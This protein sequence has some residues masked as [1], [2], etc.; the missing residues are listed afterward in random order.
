MEYIK[1]LLGTGLTIT[2]AWMLFANSLLKP[3]VLRWRGVLNS[4]PFIRRGE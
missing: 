1:L 3:Y 4:K 2:F